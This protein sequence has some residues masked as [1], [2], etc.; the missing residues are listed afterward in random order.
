ME[1]PI[2]EELYRVVYGGKDIRTSF[3]DIIRRATKEEDG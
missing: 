2:T 3:E 1:M